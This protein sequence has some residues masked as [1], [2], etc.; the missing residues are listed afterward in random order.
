M[1]FLGISRYEFRKW[2]EAGLLKPHTR[3]DPHRLGGKNGVRGQ[4]A[5]FLVTEVAAIRLNS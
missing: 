1:Q 3:P 2:L 5:L 4:R